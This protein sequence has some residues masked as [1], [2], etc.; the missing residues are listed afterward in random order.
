VGVE[1]NERARVGWI[2]VGVWKDAL[3]AREWGLERGWCLDAVEKRV[4]SAV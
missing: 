4:G 2:P 1:E 3:Y